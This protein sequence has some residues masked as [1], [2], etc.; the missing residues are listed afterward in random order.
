ML[1]DEYRFQG[2]HAQRY[3]REKDTSVR[4]EARSDAVADQP[5]GSQVAEQVGLVAQLQQDSPLVGVVP[6]AEHAQQLRA[7]PAVVPGMLVIIATCTQLQATCGYCSQVQGGASFKVRMAVEITVDR[8]SWSC[9]PEAV[10]VT[11]MLSV[12]SN[13]GLAGRTTGCRRRW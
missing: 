7:Q 1:H 13:K 6:R 11:T 5:P 4:S 3:P 12:S 10:T 2:G 8:Y 9:R